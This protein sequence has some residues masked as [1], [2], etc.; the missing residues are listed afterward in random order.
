MIISEQDSFWPRCTC[1]K[2]RWYDREMVQVG[3]RRQSLH[4]CSPNRSQQVFSDVSLPGGG[5]IA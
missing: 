2:A 1:T 3:R 4:R 5:Q